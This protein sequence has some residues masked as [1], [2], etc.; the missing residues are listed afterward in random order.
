MAEHWIPSGE[1]IRVLAQLYDASDRYAEYEVSLAVAEDTLLNRLA[2]GALRARAKIGE[3]SSGNPLGEEKIE[4]F[5]DEILPS[6]FWCALQVCDER[7]RHLDWVAG[8]FNYF[9]GSDERCMSGKAFNVYFEASAV[10]GAAS[11]QDEEVPQS[12]NIRNGGRPTRFD[13]PDAVLA[14]FGLIYRGELKPANQADIERALLL[15]LSDGENAPSESTV[16]PYAKKIW[17]EY[18]KA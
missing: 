4:F 5:N 18:L 10:P 11:V 8:D 13:W 12:T 2:N 6:R 3:M 15:H 14:V 7:E 16:R 17:A 9:G 1:A